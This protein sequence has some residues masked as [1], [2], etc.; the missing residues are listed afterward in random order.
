MSN[1]NKSYKI[2]KLDFGF[3]PSQ[4]SVN[5]KRKRNAS[6][7]R[8]EYTTFNLRHYIG[9]L[10]I[11]AKKTVRI[12]KNGFVKVKWKVSRSIFFGRGVYFK[13]ILSF[14]IL[15]ITVF[16]T[17]VYLSINPEF[18]E[19]V[20]AMSRYNTDGQMNDGTLFSA[21]SQTVF[22]A[23]QFKP[24]KYTVGTDDTLS[25]IAEKLSSKDNKINVDSIRWANNLQ[26]DDVLIQGMVLEIP[27][28]NG[29][30]HS[31][32]KGE[33]L[34]AIARK[35]HPDLKDAAKNTEEGKAKLNGIMQEIVDVNLLDV[36][37][38]G[39]EKQA[40]V[41]EG[42]KLIIPDGVIVDKP[43]PPPKVASKPSTGSSSSSS[44]SRTSSPPARAVRHSGYFQWPLI[45][46][47][48]Y[49]SQVYKPYTGHFAIDIAAPF[50]T[51][52]VSIADGYV[53]FVGRVKTG[54]GNVVRVKFDNGY[55]A[56]Y[57]HMSTFAVSRGQRVAKNQVV[58]HIGLTGITTGP[59]VHFEMRQSN[60][61]RINPLPQVCSSYVSACRGYG[62]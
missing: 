61:V 27:P 22:N 30:I 46:N 54:G 11:I 43:S 8:D 49:I 28:I 23:V 36:R 41:I 35:Y 6:K 60:G 4:Y 5:N 26:E 31:V 1:T 39:E 13:Y 10:V 16:G 33:K 37:F 21:G 9:S 48:G 58:G 50:G 12:I 40:I 15:L 62:Y 19:E 25:S 29:I 34:E 57:M 45:G 47:S 24:V 52:L 3:N 59:H 14:S 55:E 7:D 2:D 42:Q 17:F 56:A 51:S 53:T 20:Y 32:K 18:S 38:I 44:A